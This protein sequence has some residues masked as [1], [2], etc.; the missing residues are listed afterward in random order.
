MKKLIIDHPRLLFAFLL[1]CLLTCFSSQVYPDTPDVQQRLPQNIERPIKVGVTFVL[2]NITNLDEKQGL[3]QA[4]IDLTTSWTNP[5][6]AFDPKVVGQ[7]MLILNDT[8]T[9]EKLKTIWSPDIT[10]SNLDKIN[11]IDPSM[12]IMS[13][14]TANYVQRI[15]AVFKMHP[16]LRTFPFD[17]QYLVF[18][19]DAKKN[20]TSEIRFYQDQQE[21]NKS[22]VRQGTS[23]DGWTLDKV[24]FENSVVRGASGSFYPRFEIKIIMSR[25]SE[26]H[27]YSFVPLLLIVLAPTVL[28]LYFTADLATRLGAWAAGLLTLIATDF[29]LDQKYPALGANSILTITFSI[30]LFYQIVMIFLTMTF[31]NP[32]FVSKLKNPFLAESVV[33]YLQ[34]VTPIV[35]FLIIISRILLTASPV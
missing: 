1:T 21:I 9:K 20:T 8:E 2:N 5:D 16:D 7:T 14:G 35:L 29:A 34:W 18:Y 30:I 10:I 23:L 11:S 25:I 28:T 31:V 32:N 19:L 3:F 24:V 26:P 33:T 12:T 27:I 4:D 13:D 15:Q 22:G 6:I 17:T